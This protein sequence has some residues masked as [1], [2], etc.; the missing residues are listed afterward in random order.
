MRVL[1]AIYSSIALI[2]FIALLMHQFMIS[3][4]PLRNY[5]TFNGVD[6]ISGMLLPI[7][8]SSGL[9]IDIYGKP[10]NYTCINS[11]MMW[12]SNDYVTEAPLLNG[13]PFLV[14]VMRGEN[15]LSVIEVTPPSVNFTILNP[16]MNYSYYSSSV[17]AFIPLDW[18]AEAAPPPLNT[19]FSGEGFTF[20]TRNQFAM[21]A[22]YIRSWGLEFIEWRCSNG[23]IV[24][25]NETSIV[26]PSSGVEWL[27][28]AP[29][30]WGIEA[31]GNCTVTLGRWSTA[32]GTSK[33]S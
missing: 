3:S 19:S 27:R 30:A 12:I 4:V 8:C 21:L 33:K 9:Y 5:T 28:A 17:D 26:L 16:G 14:T 18:N 22:T 13:E 29:G 24:L 7:N 2:A 31:S 25:I 23:S 20:T 11:T 1:V 15:V 10:W 32:V 6:V